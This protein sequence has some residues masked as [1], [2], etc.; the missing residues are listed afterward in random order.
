MACTQRMHT[1]TRTHARV[2]LIS[3]P[4]R[5]TAVC[6]EAVRCGSAGAVMAC[7]CA[8]QQLQR[9]APWHRPRLALAKVA[10]VRSNGPPALH[11]R[12][13]EHCVCMRARACVVVCVRVRGVR[14]HTLWRAQDGGRTQ[15]QPCRAFKQRWPCGLVGAC[16]H[17]AD[18]AHPWSGWCAPRHSQLPS[19]CTAV[20]ALHPAAHLLCRVGP[21]NTPLAF[22]PT[23]RASPQGTVLQGGALRPPA[24]RFSSWHHPAW[25]RWSRGHGGAADSW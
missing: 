20:C 15:A 21:P 23:H 25:S 3:V 2:P 18:T 1:R 9:R 17:Q 11:C 24:W 7:R 19:S 6:A 8:G 14:V 4:S 10:K 13:A 22:G 12:V 16:V 5:C